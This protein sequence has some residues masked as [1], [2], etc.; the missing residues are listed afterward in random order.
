MT[1]DDPITSHRSALLGLAYRITGDP[2]DAEEVVQDAMV[3]AIERPPPDTSRS[4]RP[5]LMRVTA[6][7]ARDRLRR[8]RRAPYFGTWLPGPIDTGGP[9]AG[10]MAIEPSPGP[11]ARYSARQSV[12]FAFL[13]AL[14]TLTP[15]QRTVLVLRDVY[16]LSVV[17]TSEALGIGESNVKVTLHRARR[18]L[19]AAGVPAEPTE[20]RRA[21]VEATLQALFEAMMSRDLD[22]VVGLLADDPVGRGDGGG[23]SP[24]TPRPHRGVLRVSRAI[25]SARLQAWPLTMERREI[26]GEPAWVIEQ[27][28]DVRDGPHRLVA[29]IDVD[30]RGLVR[31]YEV[32]TSPAK[33]RALDHVWKQPIC[34]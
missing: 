21:Q 8:R 34:G 7:L 26:N 15:Q 24:A 29:R 13:I 30:E 31:V 17:E 3:R 6:N 2:S 23:L 32:V 27:P 14:E 5:W 9:Q 1:P 19:E 10:W 16:D 25:L 20:A 12:T 11:E 28:L 22:A 18:R 33:L 4:L